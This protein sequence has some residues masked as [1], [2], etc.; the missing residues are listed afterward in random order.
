MKKIVIFF[1]IFFLGASH[2]TLALEISTWVSTEKVG[3]FSTLEKIDKEKT[4][5]TEKEWQIDFEEKRISDYTLK[6]ETLT[7]QYNEILNLEKLYQELKNSITPESQNDEVL[8][9]AYLDSQADLDQKIAIFLEGIKFEVTDKQIDYDFFQTFQRDIKKALDETLKK[10]SEDVISSQGLLVE[11]Q[12]EVEKLEENLNK[13]EIALQLQIKDIIYK[14]IFFLVTFLV[15][16][17]LSKIAQKWIRNKESFSEEK[18]QVLLSI[19]R[20]IKNILLFSVIIFFFFSEFLTILPFL[21]ILWTALWFALRDVIS[22]FIAW[23]VIGL[24]DGIYGVGD[25]IEMENENVFGRVIK[26]TPLITVIQELG[27]SWPNGMY[28]SFPNKKIFESSIK[29]IWKQKGWIFI[30]TDF[31]METKSDI[32][33]AKKILIEVMN[34]VSIQEKF[35]QPLSQKSFLKKFWHTEESLKPQVFLE[36]RPQWVL[37]RGKVPVMWGERHM[38]RTEIIERFAKKTQKLRSIKFRYVEIGGNFIN[39][40]N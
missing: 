39:G 12:D 19:V 22:S 38:M 5:V 29:N 11:Y 27:L 2:Q 33:L 40:K 36:I 34:G 3:I 24:K 30:S 23:F 15:L 4:A 28:R 20:W 37:L 7:E 31:L 1:V 13:S 18:K 21:A 26:I 16:Y 32:E 8:Q 35:S 14:L 10:L 6:I 17:F 25:V 9:K